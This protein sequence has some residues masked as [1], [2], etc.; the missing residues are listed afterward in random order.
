MF[1]AQEGAAGERSGLSRFAREVVLLGGGGLLAVW[2]LA[3]LSYSVQ[4]AAWSTSGTGV[5]VQ[6]QAGRLGA[7]LA[8]ASFFL[9]G[10]SVWWCV[11]AAIRAWL[12]ALAA[13]LRSHELFFVG[14]T[15][16]DAPEH[17]LSAR[18][19]FWLGLSLLVLASST[20]EWTRMYSL[21]ARLPGHGGG[22]LGYFVGPLSVHW[23][24]FAGSGLVAIAVALV[25]LSLTFGF[26]WAQVSERL[27]AWLFSRIENRR[28]QRELAQDM[29]LGQ[30]AATEREEVLVEQRQDQAVNR[31]KP[32]AIEPLPL[33]LPKSE[34]VAKERQKPLFH[35]LADSKLPQVDLLTRRCNAR[36][37][38]PRKRWK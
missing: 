29:A 18:T 3:L 28:E 14:H 34:R 31:P 35:E 16:P 20:L 37:R 25:G 4:D 7:W 23:L 5:V 9:L 36:K 21:E 13:W 1:P 12:S 33:E 38:W 30:Q 11:A 15:V 26:S 17:W 27:G 19:R 24:G 6:N 22:I 8:D 2:L 32:L 10:F